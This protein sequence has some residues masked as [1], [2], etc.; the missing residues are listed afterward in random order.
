LL[1]AAF[2]AIVLAVDPDLRAFKD[3]ELQ[4][5]KSY[6]SHAERMRRF[7]IFKQNLR[8]AEQLTL[9]SN[10]LAEHGV[11]QFMDLSPEE[12]KAIYLNLLLPNTTSNRRFLKVPNLPA[13]PTSWNWADHGGVTAVKDQGSCGSCWAFSAAEQIESIWM[14]GG[15]PTVTLSP[16]QL[17][18]CD[19]TCYGCDGGWPLYGFRYVDTAGGIMASSAYP[20][21][22]KDGTCKFSSSKVVAWITNFGYVSGG[23]S[24][25]L[26][27]VGSVGPVSVAV[28]A[29][30]WQTYKSGVLSS[31]GTSLNHAVQTVGYGTVNNVA[32]WIVRNSW[33]STWGVGGYIYVPRNRNFC[34]INEE[35][36]SV[37]I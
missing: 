9:E 25:I 8:R 13:A 20:Y 3:F 6:V 29:T 31:C 28:D 35:V 34:G 4:Y 36:T 10:G 15:N 26:N 32:V 18:D 19:K 37:E 21:T 22:G 14:L 2:V 5:S 33:G 24:G 16:Q 27:Y 12:F 1:L 30:T 7:Q 11:T 23:E 17:V